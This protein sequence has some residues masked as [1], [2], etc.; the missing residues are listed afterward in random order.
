M[1]DLLESIIKDMKGLH[2]IGLISDEVYEAF[3]EDISE[4]GYEVD[5]D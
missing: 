1:T 4:S 2:E 5:Y 3:L